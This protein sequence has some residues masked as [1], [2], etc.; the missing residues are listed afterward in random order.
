MTALQGKHI[1]TTQAVALAKSLQLRSEELGN[2]PETDLSTLCDRWIKR[3]SGATPERLVEAL[4]CCEG[5]GKYVSGI[6][7]E[8]VSMFHKD[9]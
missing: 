2:P 8:Y 1:S 3:D 6:G 7:C 9:S 5:L 4:M